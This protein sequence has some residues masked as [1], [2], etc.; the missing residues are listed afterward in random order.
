MLNRWLL[1]RFDFFGA[2]ATLGTTVF[3]LARL[4]A[5]LAGLTIT[6]SM[7]FTMSVYCKLIPI[8]Q[9]CSITADMFDSRDVPDGYAT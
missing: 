3:A 9:S 5:G 8:S 4:D 7:A 1:L 6:A 2:L